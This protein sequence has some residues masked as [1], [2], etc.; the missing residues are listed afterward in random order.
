VVIDGL[1]IRNELTSP[2]Q[3]RRIINEA[4][5]SLMVDL[6]AGRLTGV[7]ADKVGEGNPA[8]ITNGIWG[9]N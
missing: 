8:Q 4:L 6:G 1:V 7:L 2:I 5:Q 9:K 3:G